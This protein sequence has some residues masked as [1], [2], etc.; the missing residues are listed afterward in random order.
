MFSV[1]F[2]IYSKWNGAT[3][4]PEADEIQLK[5]AI[6]KAHAL[7]KPVR[8]WDAPD[9][10]NAGY[11]FMLLQVDYINTDHIAELASF[12]NEK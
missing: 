12:L 1:D 10:K 5:T 7:Q 2:G 6:K 4:I 8:F 11:E 3:E 9:I